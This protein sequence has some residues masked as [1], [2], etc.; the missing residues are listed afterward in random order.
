[1]D[2]IPLIH[3]VTRSCVCLLDWD[4]EEPVLFP[5]LF[6]PNSCCS[7]CEASSFTR[8]GSRRDVSGTAEED[9][10]VPLLV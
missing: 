4:G 9:V 8:R 3:L 1:M 5:S 7:L 10:M 6:S 2:F